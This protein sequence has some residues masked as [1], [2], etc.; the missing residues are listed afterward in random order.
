MS[1]SLLDCEP[2]SHNDEQEIIE[3]LARDQKEVSPKYFYD[4]TGSQLFEEICEQPEYY[5]T[6]TELGIMRERIDEIARLIGPNA[7]IIEFGSGASVKTRLLLE[8]APELAAYV[9]VDISRDH[10]ASTAETLAREFSDIEV[11]PV[12]ADFTQPFELPTPSRMPERNV[13]YFPGS[14]IGNFSPREAVDLMKVMRTE[15]KDDGA[16]LIGVDLEKPSGVVER[17]YNDAAG[18]TAD[19]NLNLLARL[20]REHDAN[21]DLDAFEHA[22]VYDEEHRR[23]EMRLISL[24]AQS[25]EVAG[26]TFDF[27]EGEYIVT[28]HSHKYSLER[29]ASMAAEAGFDQEKCWTDPADLFSVQYLVAA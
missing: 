18:V 2:A 17:A 5:P 4:E 6:R 14:T 20:N 15:A 1:V 29:F 9:P 12:C 16:L 24:D 21:F 26:E 23:I 8:H 3:G 27:D 22:A 11:L 10:L 7:S 19:F 25:V 13:V 28:E